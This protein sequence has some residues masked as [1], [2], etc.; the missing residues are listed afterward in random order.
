MFDL[1]LKNC[2][3]VTP[4]GVREADVCVSGGKIAEIRPCGS[5]EAETVVD[6]GGMYLF[7]G[8]VDAHVHFNDPGLPER[9]DM[10]SGTYAAAAGG[11]TTVIDMPLS[12]DPTVISPGALEQK[13]RA[14]AEKAVV[15]YALW[16]G[17]VDGNAGAMEAMCRGGAVAFKAF[18]CFAG[19]DFPY[20]EREPLRRG[21]EEAAR[22]GALVGVHC[23]DEE[24]TS[25][26]EAEAR[27]EGRTGVADFLAA[28]PPVSEEKAVDMV[29]EE[30]ER[31][32]ASVHICH[33][34][35]PGVVRKVSE[36]KRRGVKA[37]VETCP[38]YLLFTCKDLERLRGVLKCTPP[39]RTRDDAEELWKLLEAGEIDLVCS[40]HS[41]STVAQK[42]PASGSIWDAWGGVNGVQTLLPLM[43]HQAVVKRGMPP[44]KLAKLTA[45]NP[46]KIFGLWP[47]KGAIAAG[48]D[49]D[50]AVLDP[51]AVWEVTPEIL[52]YKNKHTPYMGMTIQGKVLKTFVRGVCVYDRGAVT[53]AHGTLLTRAGAAEKICEGA[54]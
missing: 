22:L 29:L 45:E 42:N 2:R 1:V 8:V 31:T 27:A 16:G 4:D 46:A 30:A 35:L 41:P 32:G 19:D 40:D 53:P 7:P 50:F 11:T 6:I 20:V 12:G 26:L 17:L 24:I 34:T 5:A 9:E 25:K 37:T 47:H 10:R 23:E 3:A 48:A 14:A 44:E 43:F 54:D 38:Q 28:H 52:F 33:A 36:A 13:K 18:T 15:D 49:A 21:M 39:V 51:E